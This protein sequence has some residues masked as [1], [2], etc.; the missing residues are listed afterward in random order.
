MRDEHA[1]RILHAEC[2]GLRFCSIDEL[3]RR[4]R[5]RRLTLNL[6]PYRVMQTARGTRASVGERLNDKVILGKDLRL[7]RIGRGLRKSRLRVAIN[8]D[9][10]VRVAE[11]FLQSID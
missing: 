5:Y 10:R 1:T 7:Q 2:S 3:A 8:F 9:A 6:E 4:N 11:Q